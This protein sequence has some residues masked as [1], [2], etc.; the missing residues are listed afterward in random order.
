MRLPALSLE[1]KALLL[2]EGFLAVL[3]AFRF[4]EYW[5]TGFFAPDE[6]EY[7]RDAVAGVVY[8]D[9]WFVGGFN[10]FIFRAFGINNVDSFSRLLPFYG[11]FWS[12]LT[13]VALYFILHRLGF[14]GVTAALAIVSSFTAISFV[15]FS[16][17]T[18]LTEPVGLATAMWGIYFFIRFY[19]SKTWKEALAYPFL[20]ALAFGAATGTRE[21]YIAYALGGIALVAL[22]A[23][24][25]RH[26][27]V[28]VLPARLKP[29]LVLSIVAFAVPTG[30][31]LG[32]PGSALSL[33]VGPLISSIPA[34]MLGTT[35]TGTAS[36][37]V[38]TSAPAVRSTIL[39]FLGGIALGWGPIAGMVGVI[40]LVI[41]LRRALFGKDRLALLLLLL[42]A[43]AFTSYLGT[44]YDFAILPGSLSFANF[45]SGTFIRFSNTSL[46][47]F[48][49]V[50]P[51]VFS[52]LAKSRKRY[53]PYLAVLVVLMVVSVPAYEA[54]TSSNIKFFPGNPF[55]LSYRTT[56]VEVRNFMEKNLDGTPAYMLGVP[57]GWPFTPG[58][59]DLRNLSVFSPLLG[60]QSVNTIDE[61]Q[62][63]SYMWPSVYIYVGNDYSPLS[64]F[65]SY[66]QQL[67]KPKNDTAGQFPFTVTSVEVADSINATNGFTLYKVSLSWSS[68]SGP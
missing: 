60:Y 8:I 46:P 35:H 3:C 37:N 23:Y 25:K 5:T 36:K 39:I 19:Q 51:F 53:L 24:L 4:Y 43:V 14:S 29:L 59:Q 32:Y 34:A 17:S 66:I 61:S 30:V 52:H 42:C 22:A 1:A 49:L 55:Y 47:A 6:F 63:Y 65:P 7:Y 20:S 27:G 31:L 64:A 41:V 67:V 38:T 16:T 12:S 68:G 45:F 2:A 50:A 40:G 21:P 13:L 26:G 18:I 58:V 9:R 44:S 62:F 57:Q 56:A 10:I 11:F 48:F 33:T 28:S 54:L 15:T